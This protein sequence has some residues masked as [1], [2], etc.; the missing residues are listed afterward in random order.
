MP[1]FPLREMVGRAR[2][3]NTGDVSAPRVRPIAG[4]MVKEHRN[5][6]TRI[7][8]VMFSIQRGDISAPSSSLFSSCGRDT[9]T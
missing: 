2:R 6:S 1:Q 8:A 9:F 5:L 3:R 4:S 7:L